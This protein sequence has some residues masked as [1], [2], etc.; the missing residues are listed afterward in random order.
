MTTPTEITA[1]AL[2][3]NTFRIQ[4]DGCR[5]ELLGS[6]DFLVRRL[7]DARRKIAEGERP[8]GSGIV[9]GLGSQVDR[10]ATRLDTL[11]ETLAALEAAEKCD[12]DAHERAMADEGPHG[13]NL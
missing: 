8:Y 2:A 10:E 9:Q 1:R 7:Q 5:Q 6:I 3:R 11:M 4:I 13:R 12:S